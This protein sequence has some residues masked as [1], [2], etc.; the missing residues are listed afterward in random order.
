MQSKLLTK[1]KQ[2]DKELGKTNKKSLNVNSSFSTLTDAEIALVLAHR[3]KNLRI[4]KQIK[5]KDF[6]KSA[7]LSSTSTYS[8]FEQ[9]GSVSL[10]N[11]IKIMRNFGRMNELETL[12]NPTVS[13]KIVE[14]E[15]VS[16]KR[17]KRSF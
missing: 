5:Q 11:F 15:N 2:I 14:F 16:S 1:L 3:A 10:I 7:Q 9:K 17:V 6:S 13:E 4:T 8:N 12:L